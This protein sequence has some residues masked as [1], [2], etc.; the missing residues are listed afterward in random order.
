VNELR[1]CPFCGGAA[2]ITKH[3]KEDI[4]RLLHRCPVVGPITIDWWDDRMRLIA[5]WNRRAPAFDPDDAATVECAA[6]ALCIDDGEDP[7]TIKGTRFPAPAW[8]F[9]SGKAT[10]LLRA[11]AERGKG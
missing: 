5:A 4:W 9:Y 6:R 2:E 10:T 1:A 7:D 11:L 3:F 8:E